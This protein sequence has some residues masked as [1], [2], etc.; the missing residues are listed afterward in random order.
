MIPGMFRRVLLL[1]GLFA[2][3]AHA[4]AFMEMRE[5]VLR[6]KIHGGML[7]QILGN[8]NGLPHEMKYI[9]EPG[10]VEKYVPALPDGARTDDDTDIEWVYLL[11]RQKTGKLL[12]PPARI[13]Q[14]WK[15]HI[16]RGIWCANQY[17]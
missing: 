14:L 13:T 9:A 8:L 12:I 3:L 11:E 6:D 5:D 7:G 17:A 10:N 15:T 16:N 1:S 2:S 4:G